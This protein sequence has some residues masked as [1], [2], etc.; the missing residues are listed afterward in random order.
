MLD[1]FG[2]REECDDN[3]IC[4]ARKPHWNFLWQPYP[5]TTIDASEKSVG[6]P[7]DQMDNSEVGHMNI[8]AGRVVYQDYTKIEHAIETGEFLS[9]PVLCRK[10]WKPD[11]RARCTCS[12]SSLEAECT[13]T[14]RKFM[15]CS[16]WRRK[17]A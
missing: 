9:N 15:R 10:G 7:R 16:K 17:P 3:A 12:G 8:G 11:A 14:N 13:A 5:H 1:G 4:Q 2:Y 6:L